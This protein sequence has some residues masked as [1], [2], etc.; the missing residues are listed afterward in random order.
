MKH[1]FFT[2]L[3]GALII[4]NLS[5]CKKDSLPPPPPSPSHVQPFTIDLVADHWVRSCD[6]QYSHYGECAPEHQIYVND[7]P[8]LLT[9]SNVT[10]GCAIKVYLITNGKEIQINNGITFMENKLWATVSQT[11]IQITY[12]SNASHLPFRSLNIK[13]VGD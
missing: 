8:G 9:M 4:F 2:M 1:I 3:T 13:L 7:F 5:S 10:C 12:S 6:P 11:D